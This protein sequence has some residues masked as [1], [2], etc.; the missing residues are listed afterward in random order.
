M[1]ANN[2]IGT[3]QPVADFTRLVRAKARERDIAFH[4]DAVQGAGAL[5][6]SVNKLGVDMLSLSAHKFQ[7]PKG[8]GVLY[9]RKGTRFVPQQTGGAQEDNRR[10]G[11]ENVAGIVG[12]AV[13]LKLAAGNMESN[14]KHCRRLRDRLVQEILAGIS[15][16]RLNGHP[17]LRLPNNANISFRYVEGESILLNLDLQGIAVSSGSACAS[18]AE[19]PSHVLVAIGLPPDIAHSSLRFTVGPGNTEDDVDYVLSV[20]PGILKKLRDMSPLTTRS[21]TDRDTN[22]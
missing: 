13:A 7:G 2:E 19:N 22:D 5:D 17:E 15:E 12:T 3:I 18:G 1:L 16:T 8:V 21:K 14:V 10:A 11:T 9:L 4:T 6:I 20:L